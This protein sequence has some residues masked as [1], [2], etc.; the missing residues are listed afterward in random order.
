MRKREGNNLKER[1]GGYTDRPKLKRE[2][3]EEKKME[4]ADV[5]I[6]V[7]ETEMQDD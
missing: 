5:S 7:I 2:E 4:D 6:R 3:G 1:R